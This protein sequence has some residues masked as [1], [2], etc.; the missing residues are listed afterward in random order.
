MTPTKSSRATPRSASRRRWWR[1]C[2]QSEGKTTLSRRPSPRERGKGRPAQRPPQKNCERMNERRLFS[3]EKSEWWNAAADDRR[4]DEEEDED[5]MP[6]LQC[7]K[8]GR[9]KLKSK[10]RRV[11]DELR[12][13]YF[14][15][16]TLQPPP[17]PKEIHAITWWRG[18]FSLRQHA[19]ATATESTS[20]LCHDRCQSLALCHPPSPERKRKNV[21]GTGFSRKQTWTHLEETVSSVPSYD[22]QSHFRPILVLVLLQLSLNPN[23]FVPRVLPATFIQRLNTTTVNYHCIPNMQTL[24]KDAVPILKDA[25][26]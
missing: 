19:K 26:S 17:K 8:E 12:W 18:P 22:Y 24:R 16:L 4:E 6:L 2:S 25:L 5:K 15:P 14:P 7:W 1:G 9:T 21:C 3:W 23:C 10:W 11:D 13:N 20:K